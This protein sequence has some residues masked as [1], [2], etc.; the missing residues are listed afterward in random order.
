MSFLI[1]TSLLLLLGSTLSAA[2][3]KWIDVDGVHMVEPPPEH[4]RLY[5]RARDLPDLRRRLVHPVL[6]PHWD[7]LQAAAKDSSQIRLEV[8]A[9][10]YLLD[11]DAARGRRTV[12]DALALLQKS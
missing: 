2:D 7:A 4:P 6:K 5:L 11:R 8:E 1:R 3:V 10:R 12:A 9:L